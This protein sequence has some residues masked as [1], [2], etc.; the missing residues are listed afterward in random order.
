MLVRSSTGKSGNSPKTLNKSGSKMATGLV[1][2]QTTLCWQGT[3]RGSIARLCMLCRIHYVLLPITFNADRCEQGQRC[4]PSMFVLVMLENNYTSMHIAYANKFPIK[5]LWWK[6]LTGLDTT[7]C[8]RIPCVFLLF[9]DMFWWSLLG[10]QQ[11]DS[12]QQWLQPVC[13]RTL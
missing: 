6:N 12:L 13:S 9:S 3:L 11:E 4:C 8:W 10:L 2:L 5:F 1:L 7:W